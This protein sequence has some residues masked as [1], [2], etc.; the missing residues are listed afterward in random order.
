M[1]QRRRRQLLIPKKLSSFIEHSSFTTTNEKKKHQS[2]FSSSPAYEL[3]FK[4]VLYEIDSVRDLF[5]GREHLLKL[6]GPDCNKNADDEEEDEGGLGLERGIL[7]ERRMLE[8]IKRMDR[9]KMILKVGGGRVR[10]TMKSFA[11]FC[12]VIIFIISLYLFMQVS[13]HTKVYLKSCLIV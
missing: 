11:S 4:Q 8:I 13:H 2:S 3:W 1:R 7:D 12:N 6:F 5:L 10:F 9:V